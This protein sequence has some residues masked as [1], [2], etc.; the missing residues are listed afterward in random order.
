MTLEVSSMESE[1]ENLIAQVWW[2]EDLEGFNTLENQIQGSNAV[3]EGP[4]DSNTGPQ[5]SVLN[6]TFIGENKIR[7]YCFLQEPRTLD[8]FKGEFSDAR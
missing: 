2:H 8:W 6:C 5:N 1:P 7:C 3:L 4:I